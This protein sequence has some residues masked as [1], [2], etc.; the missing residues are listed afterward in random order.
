[1]QLSIYAYKIDYVN[2]KG[3]INVEKLKSRAPPLTN[4]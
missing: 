4:H 1:M 2:Y 3:L